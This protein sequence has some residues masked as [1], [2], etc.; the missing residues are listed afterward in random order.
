MK[1]VKRIS[2]R[3]SWILSRSPVLYTVRRLAEALVAAPIDPHTFSVPRAGR[4]GT[5]RAL[6]GLD[7]YVL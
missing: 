6:R 2:G 1:L 3:S 5:V 4:F 7:L